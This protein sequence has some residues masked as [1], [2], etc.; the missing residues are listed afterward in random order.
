MNK[1]FISEFSTPTK[2]IFVGIVDE[3]DGD[4]DVL[5]PLFEIYGFGFAHTQLGCLF[6]DGSKGLSEDELK[7]IEAHEVSHILLGHRMGDRMDEDE[8]EADMVAKRLLLERGYTEAA[9]L[10]DEYLLE[11]HQIV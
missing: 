11:R 3:S 7:W 4:W 2:P 6:I 9:S 1:K 5:R 8:L 10:V